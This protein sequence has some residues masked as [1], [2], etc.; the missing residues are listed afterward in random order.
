VPHA[1]A[2]AD[3]LPI[4]KIFAADIDFGKAETFAQAARTRLGIAAEAVR[5]FNDVSRQSDVIATCT[6][7][8]AA[9]LGSEHL[10]RGEFVAA[11]GADSSG[12][13]EI[14]PDLMEQAKVVVDVF[15]QCVAMGDV[16][17]A[18]A[19]SAL[20]STDI[21]A[22]LGDI[23]SGAKPGRMTEE[24]SSLSTAPEPQLRMSPRPR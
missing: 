22:D 11:V 21:H 23:V 7:S 4:R 9:F 16:R 3:V 1:V 8:T 17:L 15:D 12:K 19:S 6:T 5:C 14:A 2:L 18:I 20:S 13:S 24:K 10:S